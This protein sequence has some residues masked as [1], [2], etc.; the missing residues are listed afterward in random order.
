M[1]R[2][3]LLKK[4]NV[5]EDSNVEKR[6]PTKEKGMKSVTPKPS[7]S[8]PKQRAHDSWSSRASSILAAIEAEEVRGTLFHEC[9]YH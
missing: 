9:L 2:V 1:S 4:I 6:K 8:E 3:E 5:L 7:K